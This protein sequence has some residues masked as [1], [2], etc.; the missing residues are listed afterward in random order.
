MDEKIREALAN[1]ILKELECLDSFE[2]GTEEH[3]KAV[4]SLI[5]LY[6]VGLE[7]VK[8]DT[9]YDEIVTR[10]EM[11]K[12]KEEKDQKDRWIRY[13]IDICE[14]FGPWVIYCW[15]FNEGLIFEKTG[16]VSSNFFRSLIQKL[17][18]KK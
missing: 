16:V 7:E 18:P 15:L 10:R 12:I 2:Y 17:M 6:R 11:E 1:E 4:E 9:E 14:A 3:E 8:T 5:K 13:G